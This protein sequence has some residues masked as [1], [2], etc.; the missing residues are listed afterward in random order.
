[1]RDALA[2]GG[3]RFGRAQ[4]QAAIDLHGIDGNDLAAEPLGQA[5]RDFGFTNGG[6]AGQQQGLAGGSATRVFGLGRH[7]HF[8]SGAAGAGA[9]RG[10]FQYKIRPAAK[11]AMLT[12]CAGV[13]G[14]CKCAAE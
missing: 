6:R 11:V 10:N 2:G 1:M 5:E 4:V 14:P 7:R 13:R 8:A 12:I 9:G 3:R